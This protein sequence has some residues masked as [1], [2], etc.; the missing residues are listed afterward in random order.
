MTRNAQYALHAARNVH[1]WGRRAAMVYCQRRDVPLSLFRLAR[2]LVAVG[3]SGF[4]VEATH[5][6]LDFSNLS[7]FFGKS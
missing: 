2:Q 1:V 6:D 7:I 5:P 3:A 4:E